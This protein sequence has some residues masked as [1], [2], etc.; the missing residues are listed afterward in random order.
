MGEGVRGSDADDRIA[1]PAGELGGPGGSVWGR[2][3]SAGRAW[4]ARYASGATA[5]DNARREDAGLLRE[6]GERRAR[7]ER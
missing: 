2:R 4:E 1:D 7:A 3:G 5:C 6:G